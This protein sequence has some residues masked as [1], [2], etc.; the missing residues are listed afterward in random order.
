MPDLI[1]HPQNILVYREKNFIFLL[2]RKKQQGRRGKMEFLLRIFGMMRI[3]AYSRTHTHSA[4]L[5]FDILPG[6]SWTGKMFANENKHG[7]LMF[8]FSL[9]KCKQL[10]VLCILLKVFNFIFAFTYENYF[11]VCID[12]NCHCHL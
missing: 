7:G 2:E 10:F 5:S 11:S 8:F 12:P 6:F 1:Y 3:H 9:P 4:W